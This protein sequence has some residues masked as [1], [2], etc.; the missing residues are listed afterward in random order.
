MDKT[1]DYRKLT[2]DLRQ[3]FWQG[4]RLAWAPQGQNEHHER[5]M[6]RSLKQHK[7]CSNSFHSEVKL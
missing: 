6:T 3:Q 2:N 7:H 5:R 1:K 4:R